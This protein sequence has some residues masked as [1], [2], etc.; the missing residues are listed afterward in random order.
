M[1][2]AEEYIFLSVSGSVRWGQRDVVCTRSGEMFIVQCLHSSFFL[3]CLLPKLAL[4][5][6]VCIVCN[7]P[8]AIME[9][10]SNVR[11][12]DGISGV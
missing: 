10:V 6:S 8:H 4:R 11:V 7:S 9:K 5:T 3:Y 2:L 1:S 12:R